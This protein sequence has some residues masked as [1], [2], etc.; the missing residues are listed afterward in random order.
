MARRSS[1]G[2]LLSGVEAG[3]S[4]KCEGRPAST[5]EWGVIKVSA[6]TWEHFDENENK[7]VLSEAQAD[8]R[9][10]I[11]AGDLLLSRANTTEYVG[12]TVLVYRCRRRLLL[13]DKSMRLLVRSGVDKAWLHAALSSPEAR[14]QMS[15]VATGT[16]DSMRNIS[17]EKVKN[18]RLRVPPFDE[19]RRIVAEL[20]RR[21]TLVRELRSAITAAERRCSA[22]R[23]SILERAFR[24]ELVSQDP[25]DEP[26][27]SLFPG[28]RAELMATVPSSVRGRA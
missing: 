21:L 1:F 2:E 8:P 6:M 24:G 22:L 13:S 15:A 14:G 12:A 20:D 26:A 11:K 4:F 10:E 28:V 27:S 18:V 19:Q 3:K 9:W 25:S 17:Q 16:S 5:D 23:R 7:A